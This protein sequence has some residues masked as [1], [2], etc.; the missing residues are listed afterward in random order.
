MKNIFKDFSS[1]SENAP[2]GL[3]DMQIKCIEFNTEIG[4]VFAAICGCS[5]TDKLEQQLLIAYVSV[6]N[7]QKELEH[8]I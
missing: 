2:G 8:F 4:E 7:L 3:E 5:N 1:V 6:R